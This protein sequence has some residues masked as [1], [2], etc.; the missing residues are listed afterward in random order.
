MGPTID[1]VDKL[2]MFDKNTIS[3]FKEIKE[4]RNKVMHHNVVILENKKKY[5]DMLIN[6]QIISNRISILAKYLPEGYRYNFI[7]QINNLT[8]DRIDYKIIIEVEN[9]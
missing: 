8:C 5:K 2:N 7:R 4:L 1:L 3:D 9:E 6:K